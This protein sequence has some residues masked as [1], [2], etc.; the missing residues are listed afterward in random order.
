MTRRSYGSH[1]GPDP[2]RGSRLAISKLIVTICEIQ[3]TDSEML[4]GMSEK[5]GNLCRATDF[6]ILLASCLLR[7]RFAEVVP[8]HTRSN[9]RKMEFHS[10]QIKS[11]FASR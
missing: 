10:N 2:G 7:E 1:I 8:N 4:F 3:T 11:S 5:K 9:I 6:D